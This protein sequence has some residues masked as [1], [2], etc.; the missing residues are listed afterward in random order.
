MVMDLKTLYLLILGITISILIHAIFKKPTTIKEGL[1][2]G[3]AQLIKDIQNI[4]A[5]ICWF[6]EFMR[7]TIETVMCLFKYIN[8]ICVILLVVD[9][10]INGLA[11]VV[12]LALNKMGLSVAVVAFKFGMKGIDNVATSITGSGLFKYP[13]V[14]NKMCYSCAIKGPPPPPKP[15]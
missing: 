7:W 6:I 2:D 12:T 1:F 13:D 4:I 8:P 9:I 3:I 10:I 15:F 14:I 5:F 11:Y